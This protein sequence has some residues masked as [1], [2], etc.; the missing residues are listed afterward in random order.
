[1]GEI[2][3]GGMASLLICIFLGPKFIDELRER[4]FGQHIREEGPEGHHEKAGTPTMGGLV[5]FLAV[6]A[7]FL[8]L[9]DYRAVSLV[10]LATALATA[11]VGLRRRLDQDLQAP[12]ARAVRSQQAGGAGA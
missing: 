6:T 5:L 12:L 3:I 10:V 7:P 4:E 2:L 11:A 8:I 9:S 1:M